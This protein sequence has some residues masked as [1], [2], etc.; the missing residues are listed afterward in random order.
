MDL[1]LILLIILAI[2]LIIVLSILIFYNNIR[3]VVTGSNAGVVTSTT[4]CTP[5]TSTLPDLSFQQCCV[6]FG[7]LS[8][9]KYLSSLN[10]VVALQPTPY[11]D[12]CSG[13]CSEGYNPG[14]S[15]CNGN[16]ASDNTQFANCVAASAPKGCSDQSFPVA[17]N[18]GQ[19]M[20]AYSAS[21]I[22]CP[23]V[24]NCTIQL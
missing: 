24:Q 3:V 22:L 16:I 5:A 4:H 17:I 9:N 14:T 8:S 11:L 19:Y 20:Y 18:N 13:F 6:I 10:M 1:G 2:I 21:S 12:V 23:A 15:G 7:T